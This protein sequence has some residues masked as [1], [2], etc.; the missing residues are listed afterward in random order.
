MSRAVRIRTQGEP[1]VP[2]SANALFDV[3]QRDAVTVA[4]YPTLVRPNS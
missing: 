4:V 1:E 2:E 3:M